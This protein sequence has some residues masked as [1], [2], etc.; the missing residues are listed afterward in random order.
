MDESSAQAPIQPTIN[1]VQPEAQPAEETNA[2]LGQPQTAPNI[3]PSPKR[4]PHGQRCRPDQTPWWKYAME[5][6]AILV[7]GIVAVIYWRQLDTMQRQLEMTDRPWIKDSVISD[8]EMG[9]QNGSYLGWAIK[10]RTENVGHSVATGIFPE[11]KMI[12]IEGADFL[13]FPRRESKKVCDDVDRRFENIKSDPIAW[14]T[15]V[16]PGAWLEFPQNVYLLP[17]EVEK[18]SLDGGANLGKSIMPM[19]VGC[20]LYH[21][22]SSDHPHHTGFVY[23]LSHSDDTTLAEPSTVFFG[24]GKNIPK[25]KITL[26]KIGQFTD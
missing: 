20:V 23:I 26:R 19:L 24:I 21:Y 3:Q 25:D 5:L 15:S 9:W 2:G 16:F 1:T 4:K 8:F 22:P 13:D 14:A 18:K 11:A 17:S 6:A 7:G 10:V 12:A